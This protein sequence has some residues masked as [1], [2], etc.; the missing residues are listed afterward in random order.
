M[1]I[2]MSFSDLVESILNSLQAALCIVAQKDTSSR[3][4]SFE[5]AKVIDTAALNRSLF[6]ISELGNRDSNPN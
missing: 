6:N 3:Y 5:R 4:S 2:M 1:T